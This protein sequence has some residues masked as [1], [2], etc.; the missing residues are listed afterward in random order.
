MVAA[1]FATKYQ[2]NFSDK[3]LLL[4]DVGISFRQL[5]R[6]LQQILFMDKLEVNAILF[7]Q[8]YPLDSTDEQRLIYKS[9]IER[10]AKKI[11]KPIY[12]YPFIGHGRV[13][14]PIML[15]EKI[16]ITCDADEVYCTL[17][18]EPNGS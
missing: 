3:V 16:D 4:E 2:P 6:S 7:G 12:Y 13:N 1:S 11:H 8:F 15:G 17:R 9:V 18:Q 14:H 10:F 5:D